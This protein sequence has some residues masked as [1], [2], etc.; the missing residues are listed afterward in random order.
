MSRTNR[1]N[2]GL[3]VLPG[4]N[5]GT[6]SAPGVLTC[7]GFQWGYFSKLAL[8][9][10]FVSGTVIVFYGVVREL[11]ARDKE[12]R[13]LQRNRFRARRNKSLEERIR[14]LEQFNQDVVEDIIGRSATRNVNF[15]IIAIGALL[16]VVAYVSRF[17]WALNGQDSIIGVADSRPIW[18]G[19]G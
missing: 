7:P 18:G 14:R 16:Q 9:A 1:I 11:E 13:Q 15:I 12:R 5:L 2:D 17:N 8:L 10:L 4:S 19:T 6:V 3:L